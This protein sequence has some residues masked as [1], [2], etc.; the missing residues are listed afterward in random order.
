MNDFLIVIIVLIAWF[1]IGFVCAW[2][3]VYYR[4][5]W[6]L[7]G[8][9]L[10]LSAIVAM[11]PLFFPLELTA[12]WDDYHK[13]H[14]QTRKSRRRFDPFAGAKG[15]GRVRYEQKHSQKWQS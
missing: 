12:S 5:R 13:K 8:N 4:S 15:R 3:V 6:G 7:E 2:I 9:P 11:W 1:A 14:P 10:P